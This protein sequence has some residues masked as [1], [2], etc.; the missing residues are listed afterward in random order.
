[1][2]ED[3]GGE[4]IAKYSA[5]SDEELIQRW[6]ETDHT[7]V[8]MTQPSQGAV[9]VVLGSSGVPAASAGR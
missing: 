2:S 6:A 5:M 3:L 1:M 8:Q 4:Y 9:E 7:Q